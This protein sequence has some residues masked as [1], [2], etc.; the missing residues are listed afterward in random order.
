[1]GEELADD[2]GRRVDVVGELSVA[3][4]LKEVD[5][6]TD[7]HQ[8][9]HTITVTPVHAR[10]RRLLLLDTHRQILTQIENNQYKLDV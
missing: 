6:S 3:E 8:R 9:R 2:G 4:S 10:T 7:Q 5:V 1:M